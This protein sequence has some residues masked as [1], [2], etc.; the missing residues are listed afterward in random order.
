MK[1][2]AASAVPWDVIVST[3]GTAT[4][5]LIGVIVGGMIG[6]RAQK[7]H[8]SLTAQAEACTN[9]L[10]AQTRIY[11]EL[12]SAN[13][14]NPGHRLESRLWAPWNEAL[15]AINLLAD[16]HVVAATH[17]LDAIFWETHLR[18]ARGR[19]DS[20]EWNE[21]VRKRIRAAQLDLINAVRRNLGR[22]AV[23]L[24]QISG[25]PP[26]SD[27]IWQLIEDRNV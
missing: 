10:A 25:R 23:P 18:I 19:I 7:R 14:H 12:A 1:V 4:A 9:L 13:R 3:L 5:T 20:D 27:P 8:W 24:R 21:T 16:S 15:L 26:H 11:L 6:S 22:K 2:I 17:R